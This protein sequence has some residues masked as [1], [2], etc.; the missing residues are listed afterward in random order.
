[1][2]K[3]Y[4]LPTTY[5]AKQP[6]RRNRA[7]LAIRDG[8][9]CRRRPSSRSP[10]APLAERQALP[11]GCPHAA[12]MS[13]LRARPCPSASLPAPAKAAR[14]QAHLP[15]THLEE[16]EK[17]TRCHHQMNAQICAA[18]RSSTAVRNDEQTALCL[19]HSLQPP[20]DAGAPRVARLLGFGSGRAVGCAW[21]GEAPGFL[22]SSLEVRTGWRRRWCL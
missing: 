22:F 7:D 3:V 14:C 9:P 19:R 21:M 11:L 1:M 10:V 2:K 20:W 8:W 13:R 18:A 15:C 17:N 12:S 5:G 6:T 4:F 16:Q